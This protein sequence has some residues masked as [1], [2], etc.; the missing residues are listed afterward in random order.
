MAY[1]SNVNRAERIPDTR[2]LLSNWLELVVRSELSARFNILDTNIITWEER[3]S[4]G[5]SKRHYKEIDCLISLDAKTIICVEIKSSLS[6]SSIKSGRSQLNRSN[7]LLKKIYPNVISLLVLGDCSEIEP[8]LGKL[9]DDEMPIQ[10]GTYVNFSEFDGY[11]E[12]SIN[13]FW[14]LNARTL[15]SHSNTYPLPEKDIDDHQ[16][17]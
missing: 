1:Q 7:E 11:K 3:T 4:R 17:D 9:V 6:K 14:I 2:Q 8:T 5:F 12:D 10:L 13:Y 16:P 15:D